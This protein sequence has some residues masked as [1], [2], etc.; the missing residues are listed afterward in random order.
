M[1]SKCCL[2]SWTNVLLQGSLSA[3]AN[4]CV[5][6]LV[7]VAAA[8]LQRWRGT[9]PLGGLLTTPMP[10]SSG[11]LRGQRMRQSLEKTS[12]EGIE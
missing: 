4:C 2:V 12:L 1:T 8:G 6:A 10:S 9:T 11:L 5:D 3:S 7:H